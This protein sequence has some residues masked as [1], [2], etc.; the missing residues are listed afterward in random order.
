[1]ERS[2]AARLRR[3]RLRDA[4]Q[5]VNNDFPM[6]DTDSNALIYSGGRE[7]A[8]FAEATGKWERKQA[9]TTTAVAWE[10][11]EEAMAR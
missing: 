5:R 2:P 6:L 8:R 11:F 9:W 7:A 4:T 1:M 10:R 3:R